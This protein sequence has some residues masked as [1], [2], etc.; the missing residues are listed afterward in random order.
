MNQ[1]ISAPLAV[2]VALAALAIFA[3]A[4]GC[5]TPNSDNI[6]DR[7]WS[8]PRGFQYQGPTGLDR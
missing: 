2:L 6:S 4:T 8:E 7:P 1:K 3:S 5:G